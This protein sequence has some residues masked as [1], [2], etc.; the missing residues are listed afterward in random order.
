MRGADDKSCDWGGGG[1]DS[2]AKT[3]KATYTFQEPLID[4][5]RQEK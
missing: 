2:R 5:K 1:I 4:T 3:D